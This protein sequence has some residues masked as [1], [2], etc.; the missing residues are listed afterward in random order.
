MFYEP[1]GARVARF[2]GGPEGVTFLGHFPVAAGEQ[3][4]I[5]FPDGEG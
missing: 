1:Q 5:E 3:P 2:D 4:T